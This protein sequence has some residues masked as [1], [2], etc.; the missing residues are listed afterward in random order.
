SVTVR[1]RWL[2]LHIG[3]LSSPRWRNQRIGF[4]GPFAAAAAPAGVV[5]QGMPVWVST[6]A[7]GPLRSAATASV[8]NKK[9]TIAKRIA[10]FIERLLGV[11]R[12]RRPLERRATRTNGRRK[13]MIWVA[14]GGVLDAPGKCEPS[15]ALQACRTRTD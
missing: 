4:S 10:Y 14:G 11:V 13:R 9:T 6:S 1:V 7:C 12:A 8:A 15:L 5:C 3:P 2:A